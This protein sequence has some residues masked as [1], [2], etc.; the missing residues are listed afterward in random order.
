MRALFAIANMVIRLEHKYRL[1]VDHDPNQLAI[2]EV[3]PHGH[4]GSVIHSH[5]SCLST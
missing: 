1:T 2:H 4:I 3:C 5:L